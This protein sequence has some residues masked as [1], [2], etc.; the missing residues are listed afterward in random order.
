MQLTI[1]EWNTAY[2]RLVLA[3]R[4]KSADC[5]LLLTK[6]VGGEHEG[7]STAAAKG[8]EKSCSGKILIRQTPTNIEDV[9][10]TRIAVVGNGE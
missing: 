8:K 4:G 9:I 6:N 7:A 2:A 5:E 10:E 1:E 3:A